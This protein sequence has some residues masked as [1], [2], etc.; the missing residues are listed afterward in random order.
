MFPEGPE[1]RQ[2]SNCAKMFC[3]NYWECAAGATLKEIKNVEVDVLDEEY[4]FGNKF[5]M[6]ILKKHLAG[7]RVR[8]QD[9]LPHV[10]AKALE[11][12]WSF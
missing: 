8:E 9:V 1:R 3:G 10:V 7:K 2:C 4:L 5:E 12:G 6:E 11:E